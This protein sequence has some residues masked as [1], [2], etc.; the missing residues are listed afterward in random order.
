M[1]LAK[2]ASRAVVPAGMLAMLAAGWIYRFVHSNAV[3][4]EEQ[5]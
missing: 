3:S 2:V 4:S 5:N 1:E